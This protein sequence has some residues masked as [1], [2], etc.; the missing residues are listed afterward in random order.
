MSKKPDLRV[1][2][3]Y[4]ALYEAMQN[5]LAQKDFEKITVRELCEEA[6]TRTSTFYTHFSDKYDFLDKMIRAF[7]ADQI[8]DLDSVKLKSPKE[9]YTL[10]LSSILE[11]IAE[12]SRLY[13]SL[14]EDSM[15]QIIAH[16]SIDP[17][18]EILERRMRED[19]EKGYLESCD[20]DIL[21][22]GFNGAIKQIVVWW[23]SGKH[24]ISREELL[25]RMLLILRRIYEV[26]EL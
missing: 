6:N 13:R 9:F 16:S 17:M 23:V 10:L 19:M 11:M 3:T 1:Q 14:N 8:K 21:L 24:P 7:R 22:Q 12:K 15:V 20:P 2:K 4:N 26:W 5:L 25:E 18:R